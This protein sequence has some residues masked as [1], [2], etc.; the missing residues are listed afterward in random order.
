MPKGRRGAAPCRR[1]VWAGGCSRWILWRGLGVHAGRHGQAG[2][3]RV[4]HGLAQDAVHAAEA[5]DPE[6][7]VRVSGVMEG[8]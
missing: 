3:G 2:V 5:V 8:A 4:P 6:R 1:G 7:I